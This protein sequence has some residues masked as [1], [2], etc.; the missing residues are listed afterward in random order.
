MTRGRP[1]GAKNQIHATHT[2]DDTGIV[3]GEDYALALFK[4]IKAGEMTLREVEMSVESDYVVNKV[5][6]YFR[7]EKPEIT[8][9]ESITQEDESIDRNRY[10]TLKEFAAASKMPYAKAYWHTKRKELCQY[11]KRIS[12]SVYVSKNIFGDKEFTGKKEDR[13]GRGITVPDNNS[14]MRAETVRINAG[15]ILKGEIKFIDETIL[16]LEADIATL[17]RAKEILGI[18]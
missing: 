14:A 1:R 12:G 11:I 8:S 13:G 2:A 17:R 9:E 16:R 10:F 15:G 6:G 5:R 4:K 18:A 7:G 3:R